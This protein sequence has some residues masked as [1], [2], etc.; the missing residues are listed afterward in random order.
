MCKS[1]RQSLPNFIKSL[2]AH[3]VLYFVQTIPSNIFVIAACNPHRGQSLAALGRKHFVDGSEDMSWLT[4]TYNVRELHPTLQYLMWDYGSL[5]SVQEDE[6][7]SEKLRMINHEMS[8]EQVNKLS[9]LIS[10]SQDNM[11]KYAEDNLLK[12][13]MPPDHA[14]Q[15]AKSSV[16]QRDIQRVFNFYQWLMKSFKIKA[17]I[18]ELSGQNLHNRAMSL[19]LGLVYFMRLSLEYREKYQ[20]FLDDLGLKFSETFEDELQWLIKHVELPS[21]IAKTKALKEN[22][23]AVIACTATHTPLII[24]GDPGS[25]KTLSFNVAISNVQGKESRNEVFR[26]ID[27]Y[28][29]LHPHFYQ[30][31]RRTTSIEIDKV[32]KRAISRQRSLAKVPLPVYCVVFMDEAGLPEQKLESL[33]VLH[34]YLDDQQVSFVA[35]SN[36]VL[37]ASKTNRAVSL[38][39]PRVQKDD[40]KELASESI[41]S[42]RKTK[43]TPNENLKIEQLCSAFRKVMIDKQFRQVYG[44]R[45]FIHFVRYLRRHRMHSL[46]GRLILEALERNFNGSKRFYELCTLFFD[47]VSMC[48]VQLLMG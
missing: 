22:L 28:H 36:H 29:S 4:G 5:N 7:I 23:F 33:K 21:G 47:E 41:V 12:L 48:S 10:S 39:R 25:S 24:V 18:S 43:L 17:R 45:D 6:Y 31:S 2:T 3:F 14:K 11:R 42:L 1:A 20:I 37:D 16:S 32:F 35:I 27:V 8:D 44:L 26:N 46:D 38:F 19:S 30:C 13:A 34:Y 40:L 9:H 15:C